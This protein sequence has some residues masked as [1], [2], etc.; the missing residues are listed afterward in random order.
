MV[1]NIWGSYGV[2]G[3]LIQVTAVFILE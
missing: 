2:L 1:I 3:G